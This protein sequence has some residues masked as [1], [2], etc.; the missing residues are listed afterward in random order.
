MPW[1]FNEIYFVFLDN[2][3]LT[4]LCIF[5]PFFYDFSL[6]DLKVRVWVQGVYAEP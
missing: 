2:S 6:H 1:L 5:L 3:F 4:I